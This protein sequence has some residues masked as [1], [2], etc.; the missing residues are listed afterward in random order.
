MKKSSFVALMLGA[1][2]GVLFGVGMCVAVV[3][4]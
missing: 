2:G 1:V 3:R 4:E